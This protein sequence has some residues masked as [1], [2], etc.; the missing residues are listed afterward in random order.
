MA[1][2]LLWYPSELREAAESLLSLERRLVNFESMRRTLTEER[3]R[4]EHA[5]ILKRFNEIIAPYEFSRISSDSP[6]GL[7]SNIVIQSGDGDMNPR[8]IRVVADLLSDIARSLEYCHAAAA[9]TVY[10]LLNGVS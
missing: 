6:L 1:I 2:P 9:H 7:L 4:N 5:Q 3:E 10:R 8:T